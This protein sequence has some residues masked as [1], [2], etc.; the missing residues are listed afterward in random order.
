HCNVII[1]FR[2]IKCENIL[3]HNPPESG[4]VHVK[5]SDFGFAKKVDLNNEQTYL[6]GTLPFMAPEIFKMPLIVTQKVDIY[7]LGIIIYRLVTHKYPLMYNNWT[8]YKN[9]FSRLDEIARPSEIK[10]NLLWD[11]L[12]KML[13]FDPIKRITAF[14]ALQYPY[15]TSLEALADMEKGKL[16]NLTKIQLLL[17]QNLKL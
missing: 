7:A 8:K 11:L 5:I 6:A 14:E 3:L 4:C 15:F 9:V 13:E 10:D 2:N 17:L 12:S 16:Q 1:Q